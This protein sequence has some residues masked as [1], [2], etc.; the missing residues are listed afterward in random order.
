MPSSRTAF[1]ASTPSVVITGSSTGIGAATA[2]HLDRLGWRVFAG[3][4][5]A[6]DGTA[7]A[8][9]ASDRLQ[10]MLLDVTRPEQLAAAAAEV[11][12]CVGATGLSGLVNNAGIA[13]S[14]PLEYVPLD[15]LRRQ[16]EVNVI[17]LVAATQAF[18]PLLRTAVPGGR[19]INV[20]SISGRLASPMLGPYAASKFAV[21]ALTDALRVELLPWGMHVAVIEPGVVLT[22]IWEKGIEAA[23]SLQA[24]MAAEARERYGTLF[25][26]FQRIVTHPKRRGAAPEEVAAAIAHA[27]SARRPR[28]RYLVGR[29]ARVRNA[30]RWL[31][32]RVQDRMVTTFLA[33]FAAPRPAGTS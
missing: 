18:L 20:G 13:V 17:G 32:D 8:A 12:R 2:L 6:D 29:D 7:L 5:R 27:L 25:T 10:W 11:D 21:E 31:P 3:V 1:A 22:P 16:L 24:Q 9:Q 19:I 14:A 33:R 26:A 23:V 28:T 4:R 15:A 30:L